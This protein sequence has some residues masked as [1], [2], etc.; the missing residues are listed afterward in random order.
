MA[1]ITVG[2]VCRKTRG[3]NAGELCVIASK[4]KDNK[5]KVKNASGEASVNI[6]HLEP[7]PTELDVNSKTSQAKIS[8]MLEDLN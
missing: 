4:I 2:R 7:T 1:L 6:M 5:V 3:R 8:E